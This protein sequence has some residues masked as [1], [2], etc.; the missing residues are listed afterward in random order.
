M[1][2]IVFAA[3]LAVVITLS[4]AFDVQPTNDSSTSIVGGANAKKGQFPWTVYFEIEDN[5]GKTSTCT[6]AL[7]D[8]KWVLTAAH[9]TVGNVKEITAY[10]G[11]VSVGEGQKRKA[12]KIINH[13]DYDSDS[14]QNDIALFSLEK[15][16]TL[17][18]A[19]KTIK[20]SMVAPSSKDK[21]TAAGFGDTKSGGQSSDKLKW[22]SLPYV[23]FKTCQKTYD[24][25][26]QSKQ[27][28]AGK[29]GKDTCQG[30]SGGALVRNSKPSDPKS[31]KG[32]VGI[33]SY[34]QGCGSNAGVYIR[35]SAYYKDFIVKKTGKKIPTITK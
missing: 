10:A 4:T 33:V 28:C 3:L 25:I 27:V 20:I 2:S 9:C 7:I 1:R 26:K 19:V 23:A 24:D 32:I 11:S 35:A 15:E 29:K 17:N 14:K 12:A 6:G 5:K 22:V 8:K 18:S 16:F 21:Y 13:P 34:G 30:D 31:N